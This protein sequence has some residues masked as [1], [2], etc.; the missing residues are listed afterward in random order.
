M[1]NLADHVRRHGE[2]RVKRTAKWKIIKSAF[3]S[4]CLYCGIKVGRCHLSVDRFIPRINGGGVFFWNIVPACTK[5]N[6]IKGDKTLKE[7]LDKYKNIYNLFSIQQ[8]WIDAF[9]IILKYYLKYEE[10][11]KNRYTKDY[12]SKCEKEF[13]SVI[14]ALRTNNYER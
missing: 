10:D 12:F 14:N 13:S 8:R 4:K 5:C 2:Y 11:F 1:A 9:L 6:S 7:F 3:E